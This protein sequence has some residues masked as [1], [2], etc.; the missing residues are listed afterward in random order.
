M[1]LTQF[2]T[3]LLAKTE[4]MHKAEPKGHHVSF[5]N[6]F[7]YLIITLIILFALLHFAKKGFNGRVFKGWLAGAAEQLY[8]F[9]ENMVVG[10]IGPHGR[11][12]MPMI[13]TFWLVIFVSNIVSLFAPHA[14]TAD[15]N[16]NLG[17]ALI[18]IGYVQYQGIKANGFFGHIKHFAGPKLTGPLVLISGMIFIIELISEIMKNLSL[19]LRVFGNIDG[20]HQAAAKISEVAG[21]AMHLDWVPAGTL[22]IPIKLL[23][24]VVQALIFSLLTCVYISLVTHHEHDD[25]GHEA[26]GAH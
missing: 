14:P 17:M 2:S 20:G 3:T 25:H 18:S 1:D 19:S 4:A 10:T 12:Y 21:Q 6:V 9:L 22:L 11:Q 8:L 15:F 5:A 16:F 7:G 23:T 13:A 26:A 24:C